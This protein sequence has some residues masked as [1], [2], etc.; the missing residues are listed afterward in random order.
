MQIRFF[1]TTRTVTADNL[2]ELT[3]GLTGLDN[4]NTQIWSMQY[5]LDHSNLWV[6][7]TSNQTGT[8]V[9]HDDCYSAIGFT[10]DGITTVTHTSSVQGNAH[11]SIIPFHTLYL[12]SSFGL[13]TNEDSVGPRGGN[14]ILR[15]VVVNTSF[16]SMI[17]DMLQKPFDY[18]TL[19]AGQLTSFEFALKD[20]FGRDVPLNQSFSFSILLVEDE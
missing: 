12:T 16:G 20:T 14:N 11:V 18:T 5:L 6:D 15:S 7:S 10:Q 1:Q 4:G 2:G 13:G 8:F 19:E 17:H 9:P 3:I